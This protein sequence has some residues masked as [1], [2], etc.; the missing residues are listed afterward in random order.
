VASPT[1]ADLEAVIERI[2]KFIAPIGECIENIFKIIDSIS[3]AAQKITQRCLGAAVEC[4]L[5]LL[6]DGQLLPH[7]ASSAPF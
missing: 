7:H 1:A 2:D 3:C 6:G 5:A 4:A